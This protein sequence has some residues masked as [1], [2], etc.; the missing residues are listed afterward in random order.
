[1]ARLIL[2]NAPDRPAFEIGPGSFTVGRLPDNQIVL[3]DALVSRR[4]A[5]IKLSDGSYQIEDLSSLNG[6]YVNNLGGTYHNVFKFTPPLIIS[7][8]QLDFSLKV[9]DEVIGLVE[10]EMSIE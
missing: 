3:A 10:E 7:R 2:I 6:V 5:E 8:D 9:F 1:M 4:H